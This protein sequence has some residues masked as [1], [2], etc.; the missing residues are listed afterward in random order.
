MSSAHQAAADAEIRRLADRLRRELG[1]SI[2]RNDDDRQDG[3]LY[4]LE[5]YIASANDVLEFSLFVPNDAKHGAD[6]YLGWQAS[7]EPLARSKD[8]AT[9]VSGLIE[10]LRSEFLRHARRPSSDWNVETS[11]S[12]ES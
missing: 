8:R 10:W 2:D 3:H 1:I 9:N 6:A 7:A 4:G 11:L 5:A 12:Q